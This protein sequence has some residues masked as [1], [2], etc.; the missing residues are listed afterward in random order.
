MIILTFTIG[1]GKGDSTPIP[2]VYIDN[3]YESL[4]FKEHSYWIYKNISSNEIDSLVLTK[5]DS[6]FYWNPPPIHGSS[7]TK[8]EFYKMTIESESDNYNYEDFIDS[9]GVRRNPETE[10]YI[11]GRLYYSTDT[12][13]HLEFIDSLVIN[14]R[15]FFN[16]IKCHILRDGYMLGCTNSGFFFDTDLYTAPYFGIVR[17]VVYKDQMIETWD[18]M[19]W[20]LLK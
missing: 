1:C 11:C 13:Y 14:E 4:K 18:L 5:S 9:F 20:H 7:G 2:V 10:W 17:K 16:I 6:G 12:L 3:A 15:V 8:R 19:R